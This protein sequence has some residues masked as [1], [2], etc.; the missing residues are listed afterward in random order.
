MSIATRLIVSAIAFCC[1]LF[2]CSDA[3][4]DGGSDTPAG[5]SRES[6]TILLYINASKMDNYCAH[7]VTQAIHHGLPDSVNMVVEMKPSNARGCK[8]LCGTVRF[9]IADQTMLKDSESMPHTIQDYKGSLDSLDTYVSNVEMYGDTLVKMNTGDELCKFIQWGR[10]KHPAD[11][12]ILINVGH[13]TGWTT[14]YDGITDGADKTIGSRASMSDTFIDGGSTYISLDQMTTAIATAMNGEHLDLFYCNNC[15][16]GSLENY[17]AYADVA[18]YIV[19]TCEPTI[20]YGINTAKFL[21]LLDNVCAGRQTLYD[22]M[23]DYCDYACS[24]EWW[25]TDDD[26]YADI[27]I[28]DLSKMSTINA[29]FKQFADFVADN[30]DKAYTA[31]KGINYFEN[32]IPQTL[33][34]CYMYVGTILAS[35]ASTPLLRKAEADGAFLTGHEPIFTA[36][37]ALAYLDGYAAYFFLKWLSEKE[38]EQPTVEGFKAWAEIAS[39]SNTS[40]TSEY[41]AADY[42]LQ[43]ADQ[44][45]KAG[46]TDLAAQAATIRSAYLDALRDACHIAATSLGGNDPYE[47]ASFS[48]NINAAG[49]ATYT[50]I[51]ALEKA[52]EAYVQSGY[53][54]LGAAQML[55]TY[56]TVAPSYYLESD[57]TVTPD[58]MLGYYQHLLFDKATGWSSIFQYINNAA[59]WSETQDRFLRDYLNSK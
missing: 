16:M 33:T 32:A 39:M 59:T 24:K 2:S 13:G 29:V 22:S 56:L 11:H 15:L 19:G 58:M 40:F 21:D 9:D 55:R 26:V 14:V 48:V 17:T 5:K 1:L 52:Q 51:D 28:T 57:H 10:K 36:N 53:Q 49:P 38:S 35:S 18:D 42:M 30:Y 46:L 20:G 45:Q 7:Y 47:V 8:N 41:V 12:Y 34:N 3:D 6:Y 37:D 4:S 43:V 31:G 23:K 44:L 25:Q 50:Y 27:S 54:D